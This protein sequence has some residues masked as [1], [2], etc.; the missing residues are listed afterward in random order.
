MRKSARKVN[1]LRCALEQLECRTVFSAIPIANPDTILMGS[2]AAATIDSILVNDRDEDG[3]TLTIISTT[4]PSHGSLTQQ[5]DGSYQYL[6]EIDFVG[7][8]SFS[9]T[10]TDDRDG[11]ATASVSIFV[12][13]AIDAP[14][15]RAQIM[16]G[17]TSIHS[18]VQ[19][20]RMVAYGPTTYVAANYPGDASAGPV[21]AFSSLGAGR[22]V[23]V[24]DHQMLQMG[25][26]G[27]EGTTGQF[28]RNS[29]AWLTGSPSKSERIVTMDSGTRT[30]L[31]S[32]GYTNV[33]VASTGNLAAN[34][35]SAAIYVGWLG[36]SLSTSNL[37]ALQTFALNGG[38]LFLAEYGVG[39]DWWWNK[40]QSEAPGNQLLRGAGIGFPT[41]NRWETGLISVTPFASDQI[42]SDDVLAMLDATP[43][44]SPTQLTTGATTLDGLFNVLPNNDTLMSLLD[45]SYELR[46]AKINPTPA[47]PVTDSFSKALLMREADLR[48]A[49]P[50]SELTAHR[51]AQAVYGVIPAG[52]ER[53]TRTI[54]IDTSVTRWHSTGLYAAPGEI[55]AV[56]VPTAF[57]GSGYRVRI[58]GHVDDIRSRS[59]WSRVPYGVA[60]QFDITTT[61]M[62]VG[63]EFGGAIYI[64][65]GDEPVFQGTQDVTISNAILAPTFVLGETTDQQWIEQQRGMPAPYAEL[66]SDGVAM[67]VPSSWIRNLDSPTALMNYWQQVLEFQDYVAGHEGHRRGPERINVDVQ[68]SVGLLHAGYPIQGPTSA[69]TGLVNLPQLLREGDWGY[70][71]EL[72]HEMQR[73]PDK[74]W[75]WDN[76]YTF[77]GDVEVT[78]NIFANA[79]L[80]AVVA[81]PGTSGWQWSA[82][83]DEVMTRAIATINDAGASTFDDKNAYPFYFQLADGFGWEMYRKVLGSYNE[84]YDTGNT[85]S[86]P[87]PGQQEKDQWLIRW[88]RESGQNMIPYMVDYWKLDVS[89]SA[90][91]AVDAMNLPPWLPLIAAE[92]TAYYRSG[93]PV[94][95]NVLANDLTLDG[96]AQLLS[97]TQPTSGTLTHHGNGSFT[98]TRT[99]LDS[100]A[101]SFTYIVRNATGQTQEAT[102][103]LQPLSPIAHWKF[104]EATGDTANDATGNG[105]T[106]VL[107]GGVQRVA[108]VT[109]SGLSLDGLNDK[110]TFGTGPALAGNTDFTVSAWIRTTTTKNGVIIQQRNGGFNGEYQFKIAGNGRLQFFIYGNDAYQ[111]DFSSNRTVNDGQWHHV[112]AMRQGA[113]GRIYVDGVLSGSASGTARDLDA[114]IG[115]GVGADIRDNNQYFA[116]NID[117]VRVYDVALSASELAIVARLPGDFNGDGTLTNSDIDALTASTAS[118]AQDVVFDVNGDGLVDANDV[119]FWIVDLK[120]TRLGDANL[121]YSVDELDFQIWNAHKFTVSS[122]WSEGNFLATDGLVDSR[123]Y[124]V[125]NRHRVAR[126]PRVEQASDVRRAAAVDRIFSSGAIA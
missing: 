78:V 39:Y 103:L 81:T 15:A 82:H 37:D 58:S 25:T 80:E 19:P 10:I 107:S 111:F 124:N 3:D 112:A 17:V 31:L 89:P 117:D 47:S 63:S 114:S 4:A 75:G 68:I 108:G 54:S 118:N 126:M 125:W 123:D 43:G 28:Y 44:Y 38:G 119:L 104:D 45:R 106:G 61:T 84:D 105:H 120:G 7:L 60:R 20:G 101:D 99:S 51:T 113:A 5:P 91:N 9:Y 98:Y 29:I 35:P 6:P 76:Y 57:A 86:L 56:T 122:K 13:A 41:G 97:F 65:L 33:V 72:G 53:V 12:N 11:T 30:W 109:G 16:S 96:S 110:V 121:D 22:V 8:D 34:L 21:I 88:S 23:A 14:Q 27:N 70:F 1:R 77:P 24:P 49:A 74:S 62:Q 94:T 64:D 40:P 59:S 93:D 85:A 95:V 52:A 71:H 102:V 50:L 69:S 67:S 55:V 26:Y 42:Y 46:I 116:G 32:Q 36:S 83:P 2:N 90:R 100:T 66:V 92:D 87:S 73:R 48:S 79:A 115:V 18:G